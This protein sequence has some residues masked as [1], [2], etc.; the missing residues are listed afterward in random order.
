MT[1][2]RNNRKLIMALSALMLAISIAAAQ[3]TATNFGVSNAFGDPNTFVLVPVNITNV[4]NGP[5]AGIIFDISYDSSIINLTKERVQRGDLTSGWDSP[6]YNPVN[7]RISIVSGGSG[8]EIINGTSGSVVILNFSVVGAPGA[9]SVLNISRIQLSDPTGFNIG[10]VTAKN[11][12]FTITGAS[13]LTLIEVSPSA[14]TLTA[15]GT[16]Q[17]TAT[18]KDQN[19]N[20]VAGINISWTVNNMAVG[21]VTPLN[22]ITG[23]D[24]NTSTTF[25]AL[26]TGT[27]MVNATNGSK[28]GSAIVTVSPP[29]QPEVIGAAPDSPVSDISGATR[30]FNIT[31]DQTVNV[32]WYINGEQVQFNE[33]VTTADYTN[34]SA[35]AGTWNVTTIASNEN[36]T[37]MQTWIWNVTAAPAAT[38]NISGFKI[39]NATGSG[40]PGWNITLINSTMQTS[41]STGADGSY[42]FMNLVNGTYNVTEETK[43]GFTNVSP[44]TVKA[45]VNGSDIMNINFTN[46]VVVTPPQTFNIL[47]FKIN[48]TNN[49]GT[50]LSGWNITLAM[51]DGTKTST[52][53]DVNG[54]YKFTNLPNGTYT[55]AEVLQTGWTNVSPMSQIVTINGADK[56]NVNFTNA[57][58]P[59]TGSISGMKFNDLNNNSMKDANESGLANWTLNLTDQ[60]GS[61]VTA[62]TDNNG[63]Y[64]FSD[65]TPGNYTVAEVL[66]TGWRQ[67]LPTNGT[68]NVT[69]TGNES[70]IGIDFGNNLSVPLPPTNVTGVTPVRTIEKESLR[71]GESTN[72]I[73][74]ISSTTIQALSLHE[75][76]PVGWNLTRI[77]DDAD[78]FKN[79]TNEWIWF[80]VIPGVN[81]TVVYRLTAPGNATIGTYH[82]SGTVSNSSGVVAVVHGDNTITLDILAYYRRLGSDPNRVETTDVLTAADDW[83]NSRTPAGFER[84]ITTKELLALIDEWLMS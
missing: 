7:G 30:T 14:A 77:S 68:Y 65:L 28:V 72:V 60:N 4:Q 9:K 54:M 52:L 63:N 53:T 24:G 58:M 45:T 3:P 27:V 36:G 67:T 57:L 56:S 35:A 34:T 38:F 12:T 42:N 55:V 31:V 75:I 41:V 10:T 61:T 69:I 5:I 74:N 20:P 40:I 76:I 15:G 1:E 50:S 44:T 6:D 66:K 82:I 17:F 46:Q 23:A 2:I 71:S 29:P 16:Q 19:G 81:K 64:T 37:T 32:T 84:P 80:N 26:A 62:T 48:G 13:I 73:V 25:S 59:P 78:V 43:F 51:P 70:I 21:S 79:S 18:A 11:G 8:T 47:G 83:K 49:V 39:N 33:S 22:A